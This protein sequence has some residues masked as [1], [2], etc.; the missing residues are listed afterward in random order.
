YDAPKCHPETR[1]AV[2]NNTMSWVDSN[3]ESSRIMWLYGAAGAGKSAISQS[4]AEECHSDGK[5]VASFFF[6]R[7]AAGHN[8]KDGLVSTIAFQLCISVPTVKEHVVKNIE[9]NPKIFKAN[10]WTQMQ[11]LVIEPFSH[12]K[13]EGSTT[14]KLIIIDGLDECLIRNDQA[15]IIEAI[16]KSFSMDNCS[17]LRLLLVSRPEIEIR[18]IFNTDS[19]SSQCTRLALDDTFD[20]NKDD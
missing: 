18:Q 13:L 15:K 19:V 6:S 10:V 2:L 12:L 4:T 5:L 17:H 8:N 3:D 16:A 11:A 14:P 20:P 9:T 1:K 7:F